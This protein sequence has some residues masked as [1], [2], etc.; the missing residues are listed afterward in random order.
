MSE[1]ERIAAFAQVDDDTFL[2][3]GRLLKSLQ[4]LPREGLYAGAMRPE[5]TPE[6]STGGLYTLT[7]VP[8]NIYMP[9]P[10]RGSVLTR[11]CSV[12]FQADTVQLSNP[13][14]RWFNPQHAAMFQTTSYAPFMEG[15]VYM[16]SWDTV[17]LLVAEAHHHKLFQLSTLAPGMLPTNEDTLVGDLLFHAQPHEAL[18]STLVSNN[19]SQVAIQYVNF[20]T[21]H[22]WRLYVQSFEDKL[23]T[24]AVTHGHNQLHVCQMCSNSTTIA[25]HPASQTWWLKLGMCV[26][27][28][29]NNDCTTF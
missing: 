2:C 18:V 27:S 25:F 21:R 12:V 15:G 11:A 20:N 6:G 16:L 10:H 7:M 23:A 9:L 22:P 26:V 8:A 24:D 5:I 29:C 14:G 19:R 4:K 17:D 3:V 13:S 28:E 1:L